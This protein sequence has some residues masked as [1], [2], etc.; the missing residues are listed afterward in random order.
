MKRAHSSKLKSNDRPEKEYKKNEGP[1]QKKKQPTQQTPQTQET[2][3]DRLNSPTPSSPETE[4]LSIFT[5][6]SFSDFDLNQKV[7]DSIQE[8]LG[9]KNPTLV[10]SQTLP[11]FLAKKDIL[12][13]ANTGSGKTLSYLIPIV[14]LIVT[15]QKETK[16][17]RNE[18]T[19]AL[20]I[21]PTRELCLQ[22]YNVLRKLVEPFPYIVPGNLM[23]GEKKKS[24]KAR[25]RK[26][27]TILVGTPGR[28][29]DHLQTTNCFKINLLKWLILDEAD[30]LLEL[31]FEKDVKRI[32][33]IID[34]RRDMTKPQRQ[35]VLLS[36]T[37]REAVQKLA[38]ISLRDPIYINVDLQKTRQNDENGEEDGEITSKQYQT[39]ESLTQ[40]Y[41]V[42]ETKRRLLT[43]FFFSFTKIKEEEK[44]VI[45]VSN[46]SAVEFLHALFCRL[47][48]PDFNSPIALEDGKSLFKLHGNMGQIDRTKVFAS[49][50]KAKSAILI[51]TDVAARGLDLPNIR[52]I[53]QYDPPTQTSEYI[54]RVGRTAR[55]G[56]KGNSLIFI[57]QNEVNF[58]EVLQN[59]GLSLEELSIDEIYAEA[60]DSRIKKSH[61]MEFV[62][63][64]QNKIEDVIKEES[65][66]ERLGME[67]FTSTVR[68]YATHTHKDIFS[69]HN[70]H[71][72]HFAAGFGL[73]VAPSQ[74]MPHLTSGKGKGKGKQ[75]LKPTKT[76]GK[77]SHIK[78]RGSRKLGV[79]KWLQKEMVR[80][81]VR[82]GIREQ[83]SGSASGS[84]PQ[85]SSSRVNSEF[86]AGF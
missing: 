13:K 80:K 51:C 38:N 64:M 86:D 21:S 55:R 75:F 9:H 48:L 59:H 17:D 26:G 8:R 35:S 14:D 68:A 67:A 11:H 5:D 74:L 42:V 29:L 12:V 47:T 23:G 37:L 84:R 57:L 60:F 44:I 33:S 72:G 45:F 83:L 30:M 15:Q 66:L 53:I 22:I 61:P 73:L 25:L 56:E 7:T 77:S 79:Q 34:E 43:L 24:E 18:G 54:H 31:G 19:Y 27:I 36:A 70:I 46:I 6:K 69:I 82:A 50:G 71:L 16:I 32:I 40:K 39:P 41:V 65:D 52:W 63:E 20:I 76:I 1:R 4:H 3:I 62:F 10:Q 85:Y 2:E 81:E 49:F 78:G 58:V 28:L